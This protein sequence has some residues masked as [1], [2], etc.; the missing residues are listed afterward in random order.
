[1]SLKLWDIHHITSDVFGDDQNMPS[2]NNKKHDWYELFVIFS[3]LGFFAISSYLL[4][5]FL[6][7]ICLI[8]GVDLR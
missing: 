1:M 6:I 3:E 8:K 5:K 7:I 2:Q 4:W